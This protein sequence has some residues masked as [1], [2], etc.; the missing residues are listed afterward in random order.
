M[1]ARGARLRLELLEQSAAVS[2]CSGV[3]RDRRGLDVARCSSRR[4][5]SSV[6]AA[7]AASRSLWKFAPSDA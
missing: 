5:P 3:L 6:S 4:A 2:V 1:A 7:C